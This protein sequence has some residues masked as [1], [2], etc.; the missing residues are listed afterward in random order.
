MAIE[1]SSMLAI[2][3]ELI[4]QTIELYFRGT[5]E[6]NADKLKRAFHPEAHISGK[7]DG[8]E[9]D[10]PLSDFIARVTSQKSAFEK[11]EVFDKKITHIEG[12]N[13]KATVQARV[14]VGDRI[15]NDEIFLEIQSNGDW[16]IRNKTFTAEPI[17][18]L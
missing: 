18:K 1:R 9:F 12:D 5:Y 7:I 11:K 15:F 10:W 8:E 17:K 2:Y 6:G 14:A 13:R 3:K 16:L 4:I